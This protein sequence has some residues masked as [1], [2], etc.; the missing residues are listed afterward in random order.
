MGLSAACSADATGERRGVP[1]YA[2]HS[3]AA[4][5]ASSGARPH[6]AMALVAASSMAA[7]VALALVSTASALVSPRPF[8]STSMATSAAARTSG[9]SW[10]SALL[11][12]YARGGA[13]GAIDAGSI[14]RLKM[15][16]AVWHACFMISGLRSRSERSMT[17][18]INASEGESMELTNVMSM[19][20]SRHAAV[21]LSGRVSAPTK[22]S[23]RVCVSAFCTTP[24]TVGMAATAAAWTLSCVSATLS[25][26]AGMTA[27]RLCSICA[28]AALAMSFTSL[29]HPS[30]VRHCLSCIPTSSMG[31]ASFA[32]GAEH[33][34]KNVLPAFSAALR[35]SLSE[36][37]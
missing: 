20:R 19:R 14:T 8:V 36:S 23:M 34:E 10:L 11:I 9:W 16:L 21:S 35:A 3:L 1:S 17:G 33:L 31:K 18:T 7:T 12:S 15:L 32:A 13:K 26:M 5:A 30:L 25:I 29:R 24:H 37:P 2:P 4:C 27:G 22:S 28:G 6:S